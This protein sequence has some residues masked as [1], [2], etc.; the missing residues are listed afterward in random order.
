MAAA[1]VVAAVVAAVRVHAASEPGFINAAA[2]HSE[3]IAEITP[4]TYN[5]TVV[6]ADNILVEFYAPWCGK[7]K[8][9]RAEFERAAEL[10]AT[11]G[12]PLKFA[13]LNANDHIDF[14]KEH[15]VS[16]LPSFVLYRGNGAQLQEFPFLTTAEAVLAGVDRLLGLGKDLSPAK[17][18]TGDALD[19][20]SWLFWRGTD[21]GHVMTTLVVY[22]PTGADG[23]LL[24]TDAAGA[25]TFA[26]FDAVSRDLMRY[27]DL[28]F[29]VVHDAAIM[30]EFDLPT[31]RT[32]VVIYKEHD[33]GRVVYDGPADAAALTDWL[34]RQ[35]TPLVADVWHR[36][37]QKYRRRVPTFALFFLTEAQF[38]HEPSRNRVMGQLREVAYS[39]ERAGRFR[40]GEFTIGV[41]NGE[42][43]RS[44]LEHFGAPPPHLP[45]MVVESVAAGTGTIVPDFAAEA[46]SGCPPHPAAGSE[47]EDY[48]VKYRPA[49]WTAEGEAAA[50]AAPLEETLEV[51]PESGEAKPAVK[52]ADLPVWVHA[53]VD[54]LLAHFNAYFDG[55]LAT[56]V[57][58]EEAA[59]AVAKAAAKAAK[60]N[61][62]A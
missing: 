51:D 21:D 39:L 6:A 54:T 3:Y 14:T 22:Q 59:A 13:R 9:T 33:E 30:A 57:V 26:A 27:A 60:T 7:C 2:K 61:S 58:D 50:A 48:V 20:A 62:V 37:M 10:A 45:A 34:H 41:T 25:A 35:N 16:S 56:H 43:Y 24:P 52:P 49:P 5:E 12:I 18:F 44:W 1:A 47:E 29:A 38:D 53:P 32:S 11:T 36:T 42:K 4:E 46:A 15:G 40:R 8:A 17:V 28:R 23:A 19:L 31:D 55:S